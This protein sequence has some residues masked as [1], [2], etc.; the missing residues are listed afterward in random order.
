[1]TSTAFAPTLEPAKVFSP[2]WAAGFID[3]EGCIHIAKQTYPS[4]AGRKPIYRLRVCVS[5]N[6][7]EVLE[8]LLNGLGVHGNIYRVRRNLGQNR[9]S[10]NLVYDGR[11]AL[12]LL[13]RIGRYL[14]RKLPEAQVAW[15]YWHWGA[16]GKR[17]GG[18]GVP[19]DV[20]EFRERCYRKL[21]RM[22]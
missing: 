16:G 9:Q 4:E 20:V 7:R 11:Y 18:K 3:G 8:H 6:N 13:A 2:E 21:Q 19:A 17:F 15:S 22:K 10:Y 5:Q 12:E 1:M 14:V